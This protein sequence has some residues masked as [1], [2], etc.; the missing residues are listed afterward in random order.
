MAQF[1]P[2]HRPETTTRPGSRRRLKQLL[3]AFGCATLGAPGTHAQAVTGGTFLGGAV[4]APHYGAQ[5]VLPGSG[6]NSFGDWLNFDLSGDIGSSAN[7]YASPTTHFTP[8]PTTDVFIS[9]ASSQNSPIINGPPTTCNNLLPVYGQY[10]PAYIGPPAGPNL[11]GGGTFNSL[12]IQGPATYNA[13]AVTVAASITLEASGGTPIETAASF[14]TTGFV[15]GQLASGDLAVT[16]GTLM[17]TTAILMAHTT[18]TNG[19]SQVGQ[20]QPLA[21]IP[22]VTGKLSLSG[23]EIDA[24]NVQVVPF[25]RGQSFGAGAQAQTVALSGGATINAT[26]Q[27]DVVGPSET[28]SP[29][30]GGTTTL[31][32]DHSSIRANVVALGTGI[33]GLG[34]AGVG[35]PVK[36]ALS[37]IAVVSAAT[38]LYIADSGVANVSVTNSSLVDHQGI[39]ANIDKSNGVVTLDNSEWINYGYLTVGQFGR[40]DLTLK[41][42]SAVSNTGANGNA[43]IA[44][45]TGSDDSRALV[46]GSGSSWTVSGQFQVGVTAHGILQIEDHGAVTTGDSF[47]AG[48]LPGSSAIVVVT[49]GGTLIADARQ[50]PTNS[51][52]LLAVAPTSTGDLTVDGAG[53]KVTSLQSA[54]VGY[55]GTG[56]LK[57]TGGGAFEVDGNVF[58]IG[59]NADSAGTVTVDGAGSQLTVGAATYVGY[60]G[61]G[62]LNVTGG[63]TAQTASLFVADQPGSQGVIDVSG[64]GSILKITGQNMSPIGGGGGAFVTIEKGATLDTGQAGQLVLGQSQGGSGTLTLDNGTLATQAELIVGSEGTG[65]LELRNNSTVKAGTQIVLGDQPGSHGTLLITQGTFDLGQQQQNGAIV[66]GNLGEAFLQVGDTQNEGGKLI[67]PALKLGSGVGSATLD[68]TGDNAVVAVSGRID[69][70]S[71]IGG[72]GSIEISDGQAGV[73]LTTNTLDVGVHDSNRAT[74]TIG[75]QNAAFTVDDALTVGGG[76]GA[77]AG[78]DVTGA[79]A[80]VT[81]KS[82][83]ILTPT[84]AGGESSEMTLN[85]AGAQLKT[86]SLTIDGP[87]SSLTLTNGGKL[88]STAAN[89]SPDAPD[90]TLSRGG[91]LW[92]QG[93]Q[94]DGGSAKVKAL[95]MTGGN[96]FASN[97][98]SLIADDVKS[99]G[100]PGAGISYFRT[101]ISQTS[102]TNA[103]DVTDTRVIIGASSK[104]TTSTLSAAAATP[105]EF[106]VSENSTLLVTG[107]NGGTLEATQ[108]GDNILFKADTSTVTFVGGLNFGGQSFD[109][110]GASV[111]RI[112]GNATFGSGAVTWNDSSQITLGTSI[113]VSGSASLTLGGNA[114][115]GFSDPNASMLVATSGSVSVTDSASL[116]YVNSLIVARGGFSVGPSATAIVKTHLSTYD[117]GTVNVQSGA[118]TVGAPILP[119]GQSAAIGVIVGFGGTLDG[120]GTILGNVVNAGGTVH[121][122]HSP[123][124]LTITGGYAQT[125]DGTLLLSVG[126]NSYSQ[127]VVSGPVSLSGTV[128]LQGYQGGQ[129]RVGQHYSFITSTGGVTGSFSRVVSDNGFTTAVPSLVGGSLMFTAVHTPGSFAA[130]SVTPNQIAMARVLDVEAVNPTGPLS[131]LTNALADLPAADAPAVLDRVSPEGLVASQTPRFSTARQFSSL[132]RTVSPA[133][134]AGEGWASAFDDQRQAPGDSAQ[135]LARVTSLASGMAIGMDRDFG[136]GW[137]IGIAAGSS[138]TH[139]SVNSLLTSGKVTGGHLALSATRTFGDAYVSGLLNVAAYRDSGRRATVLSGVTTL[140]SR[141][142]SVLLDSRWEAGWRWRPV[143]AAV[144]TPYVALDAATLQQRAFQERVAS[145][146]ALPVAF[147]VPRQGQASTLATLGARLEWPLQID[148]LPVTPAVDLAVDRELEHRRRIDAAFAADPSARFH[149][150]GATPDATAATIALSLAARIGASGTLSAR[151]ES[152]PISPDNMTSG[153]IGLRFAW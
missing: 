22:G 62:T 110:T 121:A 100:D 60:A 45:L 111:M 67:A 42:G 92:L 88:I 81:A 17:G 129:L 70:G 97:G 112:S 51:S 131:A 12:Y 152:R 40:G 149:V 35:D 26:G 49:G 7:W 30:L 3:L 142:H 28:L 96:Y 52:L 55:G 18:P 130:A 31:T 77:T 29:G 150:G 108:F 84:V 72:A 10:F 85:G 101:L 143:G 93:G 86:S 80:V 39:I 65:T 16:G 46:T 113:A 153:Q 63:A 43:F 27:F 24:I 4:S 132:L 73:K 66:I 6:C 147:Y 56:T 19:F 119:P 103:F 105:L 78:F 133:N 123:G 148:R 76:T 120:T 118:L 75:S 33:D 126:P 71:R 138:R 2:I 116:S 38:T 139:Y 1:T 23:T 9:G 59:R 109:V 41:N 69:V 50:V 90:V 137:R 106:Y 94:S 15:Q 36:V 135:G 57:V 74:V 134:R 48:L 87:S 21:P 20:P 128:E 25:A 151:L 34:T 79:G 5:G 136:D 89:A 124:T 145:G 114:T 144:V 11:S 99:V 127:L 13:G 104:L 141:A 98:S 102:V 53:S 117:G 83:S 61:T 64:D 68:L 37:N 47:I 122:G 32:L 58:R 107:E 82:V 91:H 125:P 146:G 44:G 14:A 115:V 140:S 8:S 95:S 54:S